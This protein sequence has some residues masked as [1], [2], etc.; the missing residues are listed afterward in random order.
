MKWISVLCL[1]KIGSLAEVLQ[2]LSK[3]VPVCIWEIG[4][5][6]ELGVGK[7]EG[8]GSCLLD[9]VGETCAQESK[10]V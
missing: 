10:Q 7:G 6:G 8:G 5:E 3:H 4:R 1:R 2:V 9:A